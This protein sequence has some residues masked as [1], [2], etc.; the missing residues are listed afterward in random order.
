[1]EN[2][3]SSPNIIKEGEPSSIL[4]I[5]NNQ[6]DL[7]KST[8]GA[9]QFS[10]NDDKTEAPDMNG[11][12][13]YG[14]LETNT[15]IIVVRISNHICSMRNWTERYKP[16][17]QPN[18]KMARRMGNN[19]QPQY[20]ERCFFSIVFR[21]FTYQPNDSGTWRAKCNEYVFNPMEVNKN[22]LISTIA[23]DSRLL[24]RGNAI[25]IASITP[26]ERVS[27]VPD[28]N[29]DIRQLYTIRP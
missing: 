25:V 26:N 10:F 20:K 6:V 8:L 12:T 28:N 1:M 24:I 13:T 4:T 22:G 19:L 29:K 27:V 5:A 17:L 21:A 11:Y 18:K 14:Y 7:L 9:A 15:K 2:T 23:K 16:Q 3:I